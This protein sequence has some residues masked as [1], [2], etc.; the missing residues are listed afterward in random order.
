[1]YFRK[2]FYIGSS[3]LSDRALTKTKEVGI[4]VTHCP[5]LAADAAILFEVYWEL[6]RTDKIPSK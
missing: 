3:N 2:H 4:L 5:E 6:G 1:M